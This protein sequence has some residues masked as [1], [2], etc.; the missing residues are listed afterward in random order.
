[1]FRSHENSIMQLISG[2]KT[3]KNQRLGNLSKE[4]ADL[5]EILESTQEETE[6]KFSKLN[7]KI[8]SMKRNLFSLKK[9]IEVIQTTKP[10]RAIEI[11]N[12][13]VDLEDP[14]RRNNLRINGIKEGKNETWEEC[15]ERVN[16]FL[17]EKLDMDTSKIWIE[18]AHRVGE[19]KRGQERQIVVQFNS[20]K[21]KLDILRN[22]KKLKGTNFSIFEDFSK[23]TASIRKEK[24]KKVLKNRKDGKISY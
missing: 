4:T 14:S 19:K 9:D 2:K 13:L 5:K 18:R 11:E 3:L 21:N 22:C 23:E 17:E 1:M 6:E 20:Y 16:C 8:T 12:K 10:S 15:E 24:W 7:G